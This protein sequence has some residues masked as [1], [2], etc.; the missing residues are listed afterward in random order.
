MPYAALDDDSSILTV[1]RLNAQIKSL[2]ESSFPLVWVKGE[3]SNF[4]A[5]SSGHYYFTLKDERSQINAVFFRFQNRRMRFKPDSGIQ[6]LCQARVGVYE[7]RGEYQLIVEVM[8]P[9]GIGALQLA[10]EQLKKKLAAEGLFDPSRKRRM[11]LCPRNVA[12]VTSPSGAAVRDILKIFR[13]SPFPLSVTILPVAVQGS[14]AGREIAA[15]LD[16]VHELNERFQWDV[17]IVGR[18]GGSIEDLWPFNEEIPARAI[19][20]CPVPVISAVGHEIDLTI[21]DLAA[22]LRMPTPTAAAEWVVRSVE[23]FHREACT[24]R[25]RLVQIMTRAVENR[26]MMLR[27]L[28]KRLPDPKRKFQDLHLYVDDRTQRLQLAISRRIEKAGTLTAHLAEKLRF[29]HPSRKIAQHGQTLSQY[30]KDLVLF[31]RRSLEVHRML[32]GNC[33]SRLETLSPLAVLSRGY[34]ITYRLP[35][36]KLLKRSSEVR[37]GNEVLVRL[38]EGSI[39]CTVSQTEE[40][41]S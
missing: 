26:K 35:G 28:E 21:S 31:Q 7:P 13:R 22:D 15:A 1:S 30:M 38:S 23:H 5:P 17:I 24:A 10:F 3:I 19:V 16:A 32:L 20:S 6:V 14:E 40:K 11:P 27:F 37:A 4:R 9:L 33:I 29:L 8:E 36:M 18:G 34:S 12:V 41:S 2:L 39:V 25:D